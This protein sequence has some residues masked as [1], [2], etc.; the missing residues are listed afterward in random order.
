MRP[1]TFEERFKELG[2]V[3]Y[4]ECSGTALDLTDEGLYDLEVWVDHLATDGSRIGSCRNALT[5]SA[6]VGPH[7]R[8]QWSATC[9]VTAAQTRLRRAPHRSRRSERRHARRALTRALA[10]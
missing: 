10:D 5:P 3:G 4:R 9:P 1:A 6:R 2:Y 8:V 7:E